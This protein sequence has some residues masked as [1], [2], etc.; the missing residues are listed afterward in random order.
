MQKGQ[1]ALDFVIEGGTIYDGTLSAPFRAD[2]GVR[3]NKI[4]AVGNVSGHVKKSH[5]LFL[6]C[7]RKS[8][9]MCVIPTFIIDKNINE[10]Y[11]KIINKYT[12]YFLSNGGR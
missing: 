2:I 4:A 5:C 8:W 3:G 1:Q 6:S 10:K 7:V 9:P 11:K 12:Y